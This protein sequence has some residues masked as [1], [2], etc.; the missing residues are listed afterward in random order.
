MSIR[1]QK[2]LKMLD[3]VSQGVCVNTWFYSVWSSHHELP[4]YICYPSISFARLYLSNYKISMLP[5][6]VKFATIR[7]RNGSTSVCQVFCIHMHA[8]E[9]R[10]LIIKTF[11]QA[12]ALNRYTFHFY[13]ISSFNRAQYKTLGYTTYWFAYRSLRYQYTCYTLI[14]LRFSD[15]N[16][17]HFPK[18]ESNVCRINYHEYHF[19]HAP[20]LR[21]F[22]FIFSI[23]TKRKILFFVQF[24]TRL[25]SFG[26][27]VYKEK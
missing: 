22:E 20:V 13:V 19:I 8:R 25:I 14:F 24:Y 26:Q 18:Q 21:R 2:H 4:I 5:Y 9:F 15:K 7:L 3:C 12:R 17:I 6:F 16:F 27:H 10:T 1:I 23:S 11:C